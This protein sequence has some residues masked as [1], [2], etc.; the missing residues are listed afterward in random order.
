MTKFKIGDVVIGNE[1]AN[2]YSI[3]TEGWIGVVTRLGEYH[4]NSIS[5]KSLDGDNHEGFEVRSDCFDLKAPKL[6]KQATLDLLSTQHDCFYS[7]P[8]V[9]EM[10]KNIEDPKPVVADKVSVLE[11]DFDSIL[12]QIFDA[13]EENINDSSRS[14]YVDLDSAEFYLD[15]NGNKIILE[16]VDIESSTIAEMVREKAQEVLSKYVTVVEKSEEL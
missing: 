10:I 15:W 1:K 3:T 5:V 12:N 9:V 16:D 6:T 2:Q 14:A 4:S 11:E 13:V 7:L 8:Q